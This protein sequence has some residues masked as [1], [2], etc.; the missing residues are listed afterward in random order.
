[1]SENKTVDM[2]DPWQPAVNWPERLGVFKKSFKGISDVSG[3]RCV[4]VL[5]I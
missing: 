1:M 3:M 4:P 2:A 5:F